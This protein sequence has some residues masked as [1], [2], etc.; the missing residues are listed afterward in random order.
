MLLNV[1]LL[2]NEYKDDLKVAKKIKSWIEGHRDYVS[3]RIRSEKEHFTNRAGNV[4]KFSIPK[5][6]LK[7]FCAKPFVHIYITFNGKALLCCQDWKHEEIMGDLKN[8]SLLE[9]WNNEKYQRVREKLLN[10][11]RTG[12][13]CEN[14]DFR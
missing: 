6:P 14:C 11:N 8:Q 12:M 9:I 5:E 13:I 7:N 2:L 10:L 4:P 3:I 1:H